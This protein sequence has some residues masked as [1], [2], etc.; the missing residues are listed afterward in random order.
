[1]K[2]SAKLNQGLRSRSINF[3]HSAGHAP[4][5]I[6][7]TAFTLIELLVVIAIIAI[8]A[9]M[10]LPALGK[11]KA[12]AQATACLSNLK[13]LAL[14]WIMYADDNKDVMP[15][16]SEV[17]S[18]S[19]FKGVAPSWAVGDAK[20][21][22]TTTNLQRGVLFQYNHSVGIYRC[23]ADK[24]TV[25]G[26]PGLRRTRTYALGALLNYFFNGERSGP[27]YP[28]PRWNKSKVGDLV[29]PGPSRVFT[30]ID[31]HPETGDAA[32]FVIKIG[33]ASN[34][35][36]EWAGRPGEQHNLGANLGYA[37]GHAAYQRWR[38]SRIPT[39]GG[40]GSSLPLKGADQADFQF[41]EDHTPRP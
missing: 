16:T 32:G 6:R 31:S 8:L 39:S 3:E 35:G 30:F 17:S 21:D 19:S 5:D 36:D 26:N 12:K 24:S 27:W 15:P 40:W 11:A 28:D 13:Q 4:R 41:L 37:D 14:C 34:S 22:T 23:P 20:R 25:E 7:H 2:T 1:M 38:W 10:L 18:G 29:T 9:G 33:E